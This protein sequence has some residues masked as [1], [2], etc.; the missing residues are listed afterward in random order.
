[1]LESA[2]RRNKLRRGGQ[3][4]PLEQNGT[5]HVSNTWS[6]PSRALRHGKTAQDM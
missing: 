3:D 1:M 6:L 2:R 4:R 5:D